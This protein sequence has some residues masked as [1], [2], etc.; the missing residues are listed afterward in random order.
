MG[1]LMGEMALSERRAY[2]LA[3]LSRSVQQ[4]Q[5]IDRDDGAIIA[6]LK[7]LASENRRYGYL[8]LHALLRR[9]GLALNRK[10]T[11]RLY[12]LEGLQVRTKKRRKLPR[13]DRVAPQAPEKPMQRWSLDFMSDQLADHRRF[14]VLNVVDDFSRFCPGQIV[15]LSI[16]GERLARFL[17]ELGD[18]IGLPEE[19][20]MDNG[21]E[22]TSKAMFDWSERTGVRLRFIEPGK[23]IQNAF[24][25]S[26]N[27][28][29]RDECLNL[30]WFRSLTHA[31]AEIGVWRRHY[32][33]ERPHSAL[34]YRTP[35]ERLAASG[36]T[37]SIGGDLRADAGGS[38]V[39]GN[40]SFAWP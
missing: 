39:A 5:P 28:R 29:F 6:R 15:D 22:L 31:R 24:V 12:R 32:N 25:E 17:D 4:Y 19:I 38:V 26:F 10:R 36:V 3:G 21:P 14:R 30:H 35:S 40:S 34:D 16:S 13:R 11:Y 18:E 9:E 1:F 2:R 27:S 23:P 7:E 20:V 8:R 37:A 33:C